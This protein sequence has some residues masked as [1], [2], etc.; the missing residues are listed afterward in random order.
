MQDL[1]LIEAFLQFVPAGKTPLGPSFE[2]L[3]RS[4]QVRLARVTALVGQHEVMGEVQRISSPRDEVVDV[5]A[6]LDAAIA[7]EAVALLHFPEHG[8]VGGKRA[9][10]RPEEERP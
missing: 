2:M 1:A 10:L 4:E 3:L 9:A 8:T 6:P 7:V 5:P